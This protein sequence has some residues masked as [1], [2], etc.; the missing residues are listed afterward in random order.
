MPTRLSQWPSGEALPIGHRGAAGLFPENTLPSIE[1]AIE[2]GVAMVEIDVHW[3]HGQLLVIHDSTLQRTT[4]GR[5]PLSKTP[6]AKLRNLDAGGGA[7]IPVLQEVIDCV[8]GKAVLNIE[9]KGR[10]TAAPVCE[11]LHTHLNSGVEPDAF[12]I[13]SFARDQLKT[14]KRLCPQV[15]RGLLLPRTA[16]PWLRAARALEVSAIHPHGVG[17]KPALIE[18][19]RSEGFK[20]FPYTINDLAG[21]ERM[22]R[23]GVDAYFTDR[24]DLALVSSSAPPSPA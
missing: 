7:Q 12:L 15:P 16:K 21:M 13:S 23:L 18:K 8:I 14:A 5:G 10:G 11:L 1:H 20:I 9:L 6:L 19:A 24:P 2:L 17:A 4:N 22:R 3:V